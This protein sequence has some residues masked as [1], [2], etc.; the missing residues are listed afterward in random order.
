MENELMK[1]EAMEYGHF[2]SRSLALGIYT[3]Q[4]KAAI[5]RCKVKLSYNS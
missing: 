5:S 3:A 1:S 4:H 2:F